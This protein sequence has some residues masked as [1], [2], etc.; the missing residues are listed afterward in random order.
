[1]QPSPPMVIGGVTKDN[2]E[3]YGH[4][5]HHHQQNGPE[6]SYIYHPEPLLPAAPSNNSAVPTFSNGKVG[7][8]YN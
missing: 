6:S 2:N 7:H 3:L 8:L 5:Y 4:Q 1:M